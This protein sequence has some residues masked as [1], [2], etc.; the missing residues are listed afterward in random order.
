MCWPSIG[1][2]LEYEFV[3]DINVLRVIL[4]GMILSI[5]KLTSFSFPEVQWISFYSVL[6]AQRKEGVKNVVWNCPS[7]LLSLFLC[8]TQVIQSLT[9]WS[10]YLFHER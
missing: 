9:F 6:G 4:S 3:R 7:Y 10:P 5:M 1:S 8:Y 2:V